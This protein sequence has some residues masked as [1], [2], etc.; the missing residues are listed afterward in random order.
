MKQRKQGLIIIGFS[1]L[2]LVIAGCS[3]SSDERLA[4]FV[5]QSVREQSIQNRH[6]A[7]QSVAIV[8]E[9]SH[10]AEAAKELVHQDAKA[11]QELLAHQ[12]LINAHR[13]R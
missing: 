7:N 3:S 10:L 8:E 9:S 11:R 12:P 1:L 2:M 13:H 5:T 4:Q 6:L